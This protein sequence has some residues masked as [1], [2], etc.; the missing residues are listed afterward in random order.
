MKARPISFVLCQP[1][2]GG[3]IFAWAWLAAAPG[4]RAAEPAG[5]HAVSPVPQPPLEH[6]EPLWKSSLLTSRTMEHPSPSGPSFAD[7]LSLAGIFEIDGRPVAVVM[8]KTTSQFTEVRAEPGGVQGMQIVK[9]EEG[10][11]PDKAR[12]QIQRGNET[13]W[14][15]MTDAPVPAGGPASGE[16]SIGTMGKPPLQASPMPAPFVPPSPSKV[17]PPTG[18]GSPSPLVSGD[19]PLP[20]V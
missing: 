7:G 17:P 9:I 2:L 15:K 19:A 14:V 18:G 16:H 3:C 6:Y 12:V 13:G 1:L 8:D 11:T 4:T 20:P 5:R 10:T